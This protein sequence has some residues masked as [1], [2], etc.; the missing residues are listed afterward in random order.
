MVV[1]NDPQYTLI[2][3]YTDRPLDRSAGDRSTARQAHGDVAVQH[4][5]VQHIAAQH[6]AT[7]DSIGGG[8]GPRGEP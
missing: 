4:I 2:V 3:T 7:K 5:A 1:F 6:G 8:E